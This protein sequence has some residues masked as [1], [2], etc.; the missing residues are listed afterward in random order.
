MCDRMIV[1][2]DGVS[3]YHQFSSQEDGWEFVVAPDIYQGLGIEDSAREVRPTDG[4]ILHRVVGGALVPSDAIPGMVR[5]GNARARER[6]KDLA[7]K[8]PANS[9]LP[10]LFG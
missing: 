6:P 1:Q 5:R 2:V 8:P 7:P 9:P 10:D 3:Y 4:V